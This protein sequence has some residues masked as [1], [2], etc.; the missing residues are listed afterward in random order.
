M[1]YVLLIGIGLG[2]GLFGATVPSLLGAGGPAQSQA[3]SG[4]R[5][6]GDLG[7]VLAPLSCAWLVGRS[8]FGLAYLLAAAPLLVAAVFVIRMPTTRT[9]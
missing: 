1:F 9:R 4:Y 8:G 7:F 6:V 3:I 2:S 5:F